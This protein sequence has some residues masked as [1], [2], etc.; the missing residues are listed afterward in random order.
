MASLFKLVG[1]IYVNNDDA[2]KSIQ[3]TDD[4]AQKLGTTLLNGTKTV[5]KWGAAIASAAAGAAAGLMKVATSA[6]S[7]ADEIDKASKR[8]N[9]STDSYQELK[10]AA[11][12]CG[13]EMGTL[14]KAAKKLEGTDMNLDDAINDIMSLGT[15]AERTQRASE[16]FGDNLAYTLSP[17]LAE[18]GESFGDLRTR[19][20]DLGIVMSKENVD[21]GVKLGDTL[22]DVKQALGG[23]V[24]RLGTDLMPII[25]KVLDIILDHLPEIEAIFDELAPVVTDLL[26]TILPILLDMAAEILPPILDVVKALL[27]IFADL[28]KTILPP[29]ADILALVLP[30]LTSIVSTI[31]PPL[32]ELLQPILDLLTPILD[33]VKVFLQPLLDLLNLVL[34]PIKAILEPF[35]DMLEGIKDVVELLLS[36]VKK[37]GDALASLDFPDIQIP[38]WAKKL[39]GIEDEGEIESSPTGSR[40]NWDTLVNTVTGGSSGGSGSSGGGTNKQTNKRAF[41]LKAG[42]GFVDSGEVFIARE[43]G[44][45]EMIGRFGN[46]SG[47]ANNEQII[48]GIAS[49]VASALAPVEDI[50]L[51][52]YQNG[53]QIDGEKVSK[54]LAPSMNYAL[55]A[56]KG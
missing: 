5:A 24:T 42:G 52:I 48:Q 17:I 9:V 47:V 56:L 53:L 51:Q 40:M 50:L 22:S 18:S 35:K 55:G 45:P 15:E 34:T 29:I 41:A 20:H 11:E 25:Q 28:V 27:P 32:L 46:T 2:N 44:L 43:N 13:V 21:A 3:K 7:T 33:I 8:M 6:A 31:L 26:E 38:N 10:Y 19:A 37:L 14:E 23:L 36:P 30:I 49:G 16:L 54:V 12:Q 1:D 4:K 39:L